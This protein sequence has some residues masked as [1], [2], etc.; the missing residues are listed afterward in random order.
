M[1]LDFALKLLVFFLGVNHFVQLKCTATSITWAI[2][3]TL[4]VA[5]LPE[6]RTKIRRRHRPH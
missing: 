6:T 4:V 2:V 3:K 5:H 1:I